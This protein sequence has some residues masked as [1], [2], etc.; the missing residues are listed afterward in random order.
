MTDVFKLIE[1]HGLL[2]IQPVK[3]DKV[4]TIIIRLADP[5]EHHPLQDLSFMR[6]VISISA[7]QSLHT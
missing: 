2:L 3:D 5:Q 7:S 6:V 1:D 4:Y